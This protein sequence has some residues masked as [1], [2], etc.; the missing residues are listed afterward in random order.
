VLTSGGW[1]CVMEARRIGKTYSSSF[2]VRPSPARIM[3]T[4]VSRDIV[5]RQVSHSFLAYFD[6]KVA[7]WSK[8]MK[9]IFRI[10]ERCD[11]T[12]R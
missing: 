7:R 8:T 10:P 4:K 9:A 2:S 3:R 6:G 12:G 11:R 5:L 1:L